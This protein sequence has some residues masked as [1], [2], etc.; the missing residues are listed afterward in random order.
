MLKQFS[1]VLM[2]VAALSACKSDR[3]SDTTG[4]PTGS[5]A[6]ENSAPLIYGVPVGKAKAASTY[7]FRPVSQDPNGDSLHFAI[8]NLPAWASFNEHSGELKGV[9]RADQA[10]RYS[11]IVISVTDGRASASLP[12]FS[13]DVT[14]PRAPVIDGAPSTVALIGENYSFVPMA[15]D[16]NGESLT[17]SVLN[18][19]GWAE[20]DEYTGRL[21]GSPAASDVGTTGPIVITVSNGRESAS[22]AGFSISVYAPGSSSGTATVSWT[23]PTQNTDGT[24]LTD[25]AGFK[26][27]YG[28]HQASLDKSITLNNPGVTSY[29]ISDLASATWY[30]SVKAFN[31]ARVESDLSGKVSKTIL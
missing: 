8:R 30:F 1:V 9:P 18:L 4:T 27:Y 20:F 25:L 5:Q 6:G 26:I 16:P 22:L 3:S 28:T 13:I 14:S 7:E 17:F 31:R 29:V 23:P 24:V 21:S 15:S 10:G 12:P 2:L 11:G 19:P